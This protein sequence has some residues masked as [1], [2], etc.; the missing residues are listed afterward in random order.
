VISPVATTTRG[1]WQSFELNRSDYS[2]HASVDAVGNRGV[3]TSA[4]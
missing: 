1:R 4:S 2:V 3:G